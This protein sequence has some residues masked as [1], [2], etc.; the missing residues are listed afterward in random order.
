MKVSELKSHPLNDYFFDDMIGQKW[1]EF[2][3]SIKTSGVIEP[4]V[5][6]IINGEI[7]V[8]SGHQ[9]VRACR[10]LGIEEI[11]VEVRVYDN[12]DE[13][14][15]EMILSNIDR[16]K[17]IPSIVRRAKII[18]EIERI[19]KNKEKIIK[20][21]R[22]KIISLY[23]NEINNN[24]KDIVKLHNEKCDFCNFNLSSLL[25]IHHILPLHNGGN[26]SL[27]NITTLCPNCHRIIHKIISDFTVDNGNNIEIY[28]WIDNNYSKNT[29]DKIMQC[30]KQYLNYKRKYAWEELTWI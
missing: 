17:H 13:L 19:N 20:A 16:V 25:E 11:M 8:V 1:I 30:F 27:D 14:T 4:I 22:D 5:V 24:K 23:R 9:R 2:L 26:N 15:Y 12:E 28:N 6:T 21:Q 18:S 29:G 10:E 3:E 7:I